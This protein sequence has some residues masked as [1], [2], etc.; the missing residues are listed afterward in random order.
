MTVKV[1]Y[2]ISKRI[3]I[4]FLFSIEM[5]LATRLSLNCFLF[6]RIYSCR[7]LFHVV[8]TQS[9]NNSVKTYNKNKKERSHIVWHTTHDTHT[10]TRA[11]YTTRGPVCNLNPQAEN[12]IKHQQQCGISRVH[13]LRIHITPYING[14]HLM[15]VRQLFVYVYVCVSVCS[16]IIIFSSF[17]M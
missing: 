13:V 8:Y 17:F 6:P 10:Y 14:P 7:T 2:F 1:V 3:Y 11:K 9:I 12:N 4:S 15:Y 16:L 5:R